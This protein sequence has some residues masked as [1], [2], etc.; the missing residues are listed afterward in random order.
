MVHA[1][2][3]L[4]LKRLDDRASQ[5]VVRLIFDVNMQNSHPGLAEIAGKQGID[6]NRLKVGEYVVFINTPRTALKMFSTGNM[7]AYLKMPG[8]QKLD[9]NIVRQIPRFFNGT[10][11]NYNDAMKE[12]IIKE[13][14]KKNM[15]VKVVVNGDK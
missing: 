7:I 4:M 8:N 6:V 14:A 10:A 15:R 12:K 2:R 11:I 1:E 13:F 3:A 9:F 5:K